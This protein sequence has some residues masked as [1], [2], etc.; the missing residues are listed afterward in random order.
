VYV[1]QSAAGH[2]HVPARVY[3][4]G[5]LSFSGW[6]ENVLQV[7]P[8]TKHIAWAV[9]ASPLERYWTE[10]FR[11]TSEAFSDRVTFEWFNDLSFEQMVKRVTELPPHSAVFYV[12]LRIDAAGVPLDSERVLERLNEATRAPI[13]SYIDAYLG[14]GIV[15]GPLRSSAQLG[16][17]IASVAVRILGGE[18]PGSIK[19]TP[20]GEGT[21]TYDWR[22]LQRWSISEARLPAE[23]IVRFREPGNWKRNR[24]AILGDGAHFAQRICSWT[25]A[26][27]WSKLSMLIKPSRGN[28]MSVTT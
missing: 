9:G 18:A 4:P 24:L 22:E 27:K 26:R 19:L 3:V 7:L 11:R 8:D 1:L 5:T 20:L 23:S 21:P 16:E 10:Q 17:R 13:F 15:G 25:S 6:I 12:D 2:L 28:S 14:R